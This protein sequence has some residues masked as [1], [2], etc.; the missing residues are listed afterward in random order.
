MFIAAYTYSDPLLDEAVDTSIWGLEIDRVYADLGERL[1]LNQLMQDAK[2]KSLDYLLVRKLDELGDT[3]DDIGDRLQ[4]FENLGIQVI[5]TEQPYSSYQNFSSGQLSQLL[6]EIVQNQNSRRLQQGHAR[7]RLQALPPPGKAP[8][9]YKR[10]QD[11]YLIDRST[12]P[13]VKAFCE[14][15][16]LF[17]SLRGAVRFLEQKFGK[18]IA[19]S[20]GRKWLTNPVYRGNLRYKDGSTIPSTHAAI[21]DAGEAAQI[22]RLLRRN[23][24]LPARSASAPRC[25]AG[26][27]HCQNCQNKLVVA[28]VSRRRTSGDYLYLRPTRCPEQP[29]CR[30]IAYDKVFQTTV[31][32]IC[33]DFPRIVAQMPTPPLARMTA[34]LQSQIDSKNQHL[35]ELPLLLEQGILDEQTL[36]LRRYTLQTELAQLQSQLSQLPP[37]NLEAIANTISI[38]QFW[39]DLSEAER[40]FYLRE[41]VERINVYRPNRKDWEIQLKFIF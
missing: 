41:F 35:S 20:T 36:Q 1:Q 39:F 30:A 31:R 23:R 38:E 34:Q 33:D 15:F 10:G 2:A 26:L 37:A 40:R 17:G 5:A 8:Y 13:V 18:K 29:K 3:L 24:K 21:L 28:H 6:G 11:R 16:L 12:A 14:Q 9:G 25:L 32:A 7:N 22:D 19:V 27:V 4:Y